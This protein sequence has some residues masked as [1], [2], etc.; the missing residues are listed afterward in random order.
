[1]THHA[2]VRFNYSRVGVMFKDLEM[3]ALIHVAFLLL[4]SKLKLLTFC[5]K[6][7]VK[8]KSVAVWRGRR[9][10]TLY[11]IRNTCKHPKLSFLHLWALN[12]TLKTNRNA[13][14]Y[15]PSAD[16]VENKFISHINLLWCVDPMW[17]P[18]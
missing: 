1:M 7:R 11:Q 12:E 3:T 6:L 13:K 17:F 8:S 14:N 15:L 16:L 2:T 5:V 4:S 9:S 18:N 10:C